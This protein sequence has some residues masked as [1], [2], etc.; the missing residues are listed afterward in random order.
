MRENSDTVPIFAVRVE[1]RAECAV[2]QAIAALEGL[3]MTEDR[4]VMDDHGLAAMEQRTA[5]PEA[6]QSPASRMGKQ[7]RLFPDMSGAGAEGVDRYGRKPDID[8]GIARDGQPPVDT[9]QCSGHSAGSDLA[10]ERQRQ[11]AGETLHAR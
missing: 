9:L 11:L 6:D 10:V 3:W 8:R 7:G 2:Q 4:H 5:A 1:Y